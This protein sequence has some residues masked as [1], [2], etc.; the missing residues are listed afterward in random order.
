MYL[1][2][3]KIVLDNVKE[4]LD[5]FGERVTRLAKINIGATRTVKGKKRRIDNSGRLRE[6]L[7]Y[8]VEVFKN[9]FGFH[10]EM[11]KYGEF[12]DKGRKPGKGIPPAELMKWIKSKPIRL[13]DLKTGSFI[14]ETPSRLNSLAFL[15]NRKIKRH[16]IAAT[17]FLSDPFSAEFKKLPDELIEAFGLD[18]DSFIEIALSNIDKNIN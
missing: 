9:S 12:V 10:I 1:T 4:I 13:R 17:N 3:F 5:E 18:V 7:G 16:G 8:G 6:S 15:I 14:K 11:E 2:Q